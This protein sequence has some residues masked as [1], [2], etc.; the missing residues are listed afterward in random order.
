MVAEG[1]PQDRAI[2][3]LR[4][5]ALTSGLV[6]EPT[7]SNGLA[8]I[9][10]RIEGLVRTVATAPKEKRNNTLYWVAIGLARLTPDAEQMLI[11]AARECGL[12]ADDGLQSVRATITSACSRREAEP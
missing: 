2:K 5:A 8:I 3:I 10:R 9:E 12:V 11:D 7:I 6:A 1:F 4:L